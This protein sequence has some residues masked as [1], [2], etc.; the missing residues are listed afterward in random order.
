[1]ARG[2]ALSADLPRGDEQLVELHVIV[3]HGARNRRAAFQIIRDERAN[4]VEFELALEV[5]H[6]ERNSE[7]LGDAARIVHIV[8]RAAAMLRRSIVLELRQAT[9]IP[10]LHREADDGLRAVVQNRGDRGA[11]HA[12]A[13]GYGHGVGCGDGRSAGRCLEL[14]ERRQSLVPCLHQEMPA[15][16]VFNG[17][18][19]R[20]RS[21]A[22]G[23]IAIT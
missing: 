10:Q 17:E 15:L 14:C 1:M 2:D 12:A 9:L 3:A 5:H 6:V 4:H 23:I 11:I 8:M 13:H 22:C 7:M 19:A 18:S 20:R 21:T 16:F